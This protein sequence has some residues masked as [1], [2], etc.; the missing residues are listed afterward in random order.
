[1]CERFL[2]SVRQEWL[3]HV[4]ILSEKQL[5]LVLLAYVEYFNG[6]RPHQGIRQQG[7]EREV[8]CVPSAQP[9]D[10][11]ILVPVLGRLHYEYRRV[12]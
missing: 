7:P 3:D 10:R 4:L 2:L 11:I 6:A 5:H 8:T 12:A 1:M 9:A